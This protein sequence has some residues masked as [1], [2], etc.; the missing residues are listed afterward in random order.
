MAVAY[1]LRHGSERSQGSLTSWVL[2]GKLRVTDAWCVLSHHVN[3][4][5][6]ADHPP[7]CTRK[8]AR[9]PIGTWSIP[10]YSLC[11]YYRIRM[12]SPNSEGGT[13]MAVC[14]MEL[15]G[16]LT[17]TSDSAPLVTAIELS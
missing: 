9:P 2:E 6:L 8:T 11:R 1:A 15:Y 4:A 3:D 7:R 12:T 14:G 10:V 17:S 13:G 16:L 5:S